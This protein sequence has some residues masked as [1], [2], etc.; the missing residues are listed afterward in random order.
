MQSLT[1]ATPYSI[2][3]V[4][5]RMVAQEGLLRPIRG[6]QI[7]V[8]GAGPAH[9]LYFSSYEYL[10]ELYTARFNFNNTLAYGWL[11]DN[12]YS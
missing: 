10:K 8:M 12:I 4:M 7:V 2:R 6:M 11:I 5:A 3:Q 1:T 9:A